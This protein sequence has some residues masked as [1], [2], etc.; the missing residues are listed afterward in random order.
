MAR[1]V[2]EIHVPRLVFIKFD[3]PLFSP[4]VYCV[5][6]CCNFSVAS[7]TSVLTVMMAVSSA[8]VAN[9]VPSG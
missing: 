1:F 9:V 6:A 7:S 5:A 8:K 4:A 2:G 3:E